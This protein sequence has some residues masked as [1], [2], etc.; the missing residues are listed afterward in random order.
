M[1]RDGNG[2]E[3]KMCFASFVFGPELVSMLSVHPDLLQWEVTQAHIPLE[4]K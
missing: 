3:H 4:T 1:A 2:N